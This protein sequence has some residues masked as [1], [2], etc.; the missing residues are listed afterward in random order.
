MVHNMVKDGVTDFY[1]VGTDDTLEKIV[2]RM[3]PDKHVQSL[4]DIPSYS[5]KIKN[6]RIN[7]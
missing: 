3:Y 4:L 2:S 6:Y 7:H 1:E 5:G